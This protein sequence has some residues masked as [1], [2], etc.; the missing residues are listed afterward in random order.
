[1]LED[2][3]LYAMELKFWH[4]AMEDNGS[5]ADA[6]VAVKTSERRATLA[7]ANMPQSHVLVVV[8]QP[9]ELRTS[10]ERM[11]DVLDTLLGIT[12]REKELRARDSAGEITADE[13]EEYR[14]LQYDRELK[15][16]EKIDRDL[17]VKRLP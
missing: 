13:A 6:M 2:R 4:K 3:R 1:M 11:S 12:D 8:S 14:Q 17:A 10:T 9:T 15:R 5:P 16:R 7:G